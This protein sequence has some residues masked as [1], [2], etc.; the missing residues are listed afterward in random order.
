MKGAPI[1]FLRS[2][3]GRSNRFFGHRA[4]DRVSQLARQYDRLTP[5][6]L[7]ER[8][9]APRRRYRPNHSAGSRRRAIRTIALKLSRRSKGQT[10][11]EGATGAGPSLWSVTVPSCNSTRRLTSANP[12]PRPPFCEYSSVVPT[13][14]KISKIVVCASAEMPIPLSRIATMA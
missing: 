8:K 7:P 10:D 4:S 13:W 5:Y 1:V 12:I 14:A 6:P 9:G 11:G 2:F 3:I